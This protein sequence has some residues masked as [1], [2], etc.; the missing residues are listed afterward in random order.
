MNI[1]L[2]SIYDAQ[3][4]L[5]YAVARAAAAATA[6]DREEWLALALRSVELIGELIELADMKK[7]AETQP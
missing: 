6:K 5:S 4:E 1:R 7:L 2:N 3:A